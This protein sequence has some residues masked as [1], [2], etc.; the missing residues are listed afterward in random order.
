MIIRLWS[1]LKPSWG[2]LALRF[3]ELVPGAT[4]LSFRLGVCRLSLLAPPAHL[5]RNRTETP[6]LRRMHI[7]PNTGKIGGNG[8]SL[9]LFEFWSQFTACAQAGHVYFLPPVTDLLTEL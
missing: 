7:H 3:V 5:H 1:H 9:L 2:R 6:L 4:G 8:L